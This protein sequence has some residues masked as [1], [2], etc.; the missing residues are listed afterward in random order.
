M[1][2]CSTPYK[3]TTDAPHDFVIVGGGLSGLVVAARLAG[4]PNTSV[5][6]VEAGRTTAPTLAFAHL[7]CGFRS[8]AKTISIA[9]T[10]L[11]LR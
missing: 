2:D 1:P 10:L 4:N 6:V 3:N 5:L 8:L 11:C 9:R 7:H